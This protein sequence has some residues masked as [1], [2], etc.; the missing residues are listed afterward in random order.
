MI[1]RQNPGMDPKQQHEID[2]EQGLLAPPLLGR[3]GGR[4]MFERADAR[5]T[6]EQRE[7]RPYDVAA[8]CS[9]V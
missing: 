5:L 2:E 3:P 8:F 9:S 1:F 4:H 7:K 6:F